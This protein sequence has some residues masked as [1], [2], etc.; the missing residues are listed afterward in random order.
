MANELQI[1]QP[2]AAFQDARIVAEGF[3]GKVRRTL[4]KAPFVDDAVAAYYCAL[5][6]ATPSK[7]KA[8]LLAALAYF[9]VPTDLVPDFIAGF[10]FADDL[11]VLTAAVT[12]V[13]GSIKDEHR[14]KAKRAL[15]KEDAAKTEG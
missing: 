6:P 4:G 5:D 10:G 9:V 12:A 15:K 2:S 13:S 3:W 8:V 11:A 14:D 7:V 1:R